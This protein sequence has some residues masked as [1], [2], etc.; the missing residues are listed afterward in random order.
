MKKVDFDVEAGALQAVK[1][2]L[3]A[4]QRVLERN[5]A[6]LSRPGVVGVWIGARGPEP[7]IMVAV[8]EARSIRLSRTIPDSIEGVC[9][10]YVETSLV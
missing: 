5:E 4:A 7:Y 10:Y 6:I 9:I 8:E 1:T 2:D 3:S